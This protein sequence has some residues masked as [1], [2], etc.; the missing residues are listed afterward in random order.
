[1]HISSKNIQLTDV[2]EKISIDPQNE[3]QKLNGKG[4]LDFDLNV[5]GGMEATDPIDMACEFSIK[6]G[7]IIETSENLKFENI[8]TVTYGRVIGPSRVL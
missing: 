3:L 8:Q 6:D 4:T 1:M 5:T 2:V 7:Q